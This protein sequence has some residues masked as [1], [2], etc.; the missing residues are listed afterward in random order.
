MELSIRAVLLCYPF[1]QFNH[2]DGH[3][4]LVGYQ[5]TTNEWLLQFLMCFDITCIAP[6]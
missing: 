5:G 2:Y 1:S 4:L 6:A 3:D